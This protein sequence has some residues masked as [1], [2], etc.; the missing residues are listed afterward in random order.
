MTAAQ[1]FGF[2]GGPIFPLVFA[3]GALGAAV[4]SL[5][6][7]IPLALA[8]TVGMAAV[9]AA[10]LPLPL[11]LGILAIVIAGTGMAVAPAVLTAS[12]LTTTLVKGLKRPSSPDGSA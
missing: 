5:F 10:V 3:G 7:D 11:S 6:P 12:V 4:H 8:V 9:P 1:S 2:I